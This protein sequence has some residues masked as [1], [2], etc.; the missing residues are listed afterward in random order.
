MKKVLI[1]CA[2]IMNTW[3]DQPIMNMMPRWSGGYGFQVIEEFRH[4]RDL[5]LKDDTVG[6][7]LSENVHILHIEGV[8]TWER[9]LRL[10]AKLPYTL[11]AERE[12]FNS[13]GAVEKQTDR[14]IGD[15]TLALPLKKYF[16]L[17]G[18]SGSW[19]LAPQLRIP[20]AEQD[21]YS[22]ADGLWATGL[23]LG[24]ETETAKW[25]ISTGTSLWA[26]EEEK[27]LEV[28]LNLDLGRNIFAFDSSGQILWETDLQWSDDHSYL[29][30]AGIAFYWKFTDT[31]HSRIEWKHD[32]LDYTTALDHGNG[33]TIKCGIGFVY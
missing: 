12:I 9:W 32:F 30:K 27:P 33:D 3:A 16:N 2:L 15:L 25:F 11:Y 17:N 21:E 7:G 10:T 23:Y 6:K 20:L 24:Y 1:I 8:Y 26:F 22:V 19:T 18:R 4:E 14:G 31:I 29:L 5:L 13:Q 28:G